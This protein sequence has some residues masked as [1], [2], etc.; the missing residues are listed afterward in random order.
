[1][2]VKKEN[3]EKCHLL[4]VLSFRFID[5]VLCYCVLVWNYVF[6]WY[7]LSIFRVVL[8]EPAANQYLNMNFVRFTNLCNII[9]ILLTMTLHFG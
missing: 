6:L 4:F 7:P 1:M 3:R 2:K 5:F 9:L 8:R